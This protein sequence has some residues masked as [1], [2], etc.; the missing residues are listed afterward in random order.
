MSATDERDPKRSLLAIYIK[1]V[2]AA[3]AVAWVVR[4]YGIEAYRIPNAAMGPTLLA[5]DTV[6]VTKWDYQIPVLFSE[7]QKIQTGSPERGEVVVF[8]TRGRFPRDTIKRVIGIAGDRIMVK[9]GEIFL[10][11]ERISDA[12][13]QKCGNEK[14]PSSSA[15]KSAVTHNVCMEAP[16]LADR[17]EVLIKENE[18]F[19]APDLRSETSLL[20]PP[21]GPAED[22]E[23]K[24]LALHAWGVIRQ[25]QL[26]GRAR[27]LWISVSPPQE[28]P[29]AGWTSRIRW[30]RILRGIDS[31]GRS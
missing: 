11:G 7:T 5:G 29:N 6:F 28:K 17:E 23:R 21:L 27:W 14:I 22:W 19:V 24:E 8:E 15:G 1:A 16:L 20:P 2:L 10:N 12:T 13:P 9:R 3:L 4:Q 18:L 26:L 25:D 31:P 30:N